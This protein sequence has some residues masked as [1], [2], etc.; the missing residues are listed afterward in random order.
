MLKK[1]IG[2]FALLLFCLSGCGRPITPPVSPAPSAQTQEVRAIW[3]P[4]MEVAALI[5]DGNPD[6][7]RAAIASCL[8]DCKQRGANTVYWH[9]RANSD[10]Y[11]A[12][13]VYPPTSDT[14]ALLSQG[15]DPLT[16]AVETAHALGLSLHAWVNPYRIGTD[17]TR[18]Q[19]SDVFF[20]DERYY[21]IPTADSTHTL[22]VQGV[23]ELVERYAIDGVQFDDYFYPA[24]SVEATV[25]AV[26]EQTAYTDYVS[27]GG[28]LTVGD[29]RRAT[30][31]RLIAAVYAVCH[32]RAGCVFGVSPACDIT[33][34]REQLYADVAKWAGT[35]GYVDYLC[36]QL[37]VGFEHETA[38]FLQVLSWWSSLPRHESVALIAGLALYKSGIANDEYAGSGATEWLGGGDILARQLHAVKQAG[39]DGVAL[40]SH[41]SFEADNGRD[42][43]VVQKEIQ[44]LQAVFAVDNNENL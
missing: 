32:S 9:V 5:V 30:V 26:F 37:Y 15:C 36:P 17:A 20:F 33:R 28:A 27:K 21:Y 14:Q 4:Y 38:P 23:R 3:V 40:Y 18:A 12:S 1:R 44:A 10:A 8:Q 22:I 24:L 34:V 25:P 16:V 31:D 29:W 39:W 41:L 11:Y 2:L 13:A 19:T 42:P 7:A 43:A 6:A 35:A